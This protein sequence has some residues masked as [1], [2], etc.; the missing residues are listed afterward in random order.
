MVRRVT[1]GQYASM[2]RQAAQR[3]QQAI[4]KYNQAVRRHNDEVR[5]QQRQL[6]QSVDAYNREARAHNARVL[7]NRRRLKAS[8]QQL[9]TAST[10]VRSSTYYRAVAGLHASYEAVE[11]AAMGTWL[12]SRPDILDLAQNEASNS[13][14]LAGAD[15]PGSDID[16]APATDPEIEA[17]LADFEVDLATRWRGA[18][19]ALSPRNPD[20]ARHFSSSSREILTRIIE[21]EAPDVEVLE[22]EPGAALAHDGRRTRRARLR[23]CL[24]RSGRPSEALAAF[25]EADVDEVIE[26]FKVFNAGTHGSSGVFDMSHLN[27]IRARVE[28]AVRFLHSVL[29]T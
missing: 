10:V 23:Y 19:F 26:L 13:L 28:G 12:E 18:L 16:P 9:S 4:N 14:A 1:P 29:R 25:A 21:R 11:S 17:R 6:R 8:L 20:A 15:R 24:A 22:W 5:Q 7:E 2:L 27:L 3:Q